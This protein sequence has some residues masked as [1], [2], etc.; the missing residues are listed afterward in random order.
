MFE[1]LRVCWQGGHL[2][3]LSAFTAFKALGASFDWMLVG[4]DDTLFFR[5]GAETAVREADKKLPYM[6]S[7]EKTVMK[8]C[9]HKRIDKRLD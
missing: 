7:G 3:D 1:R 4:E 2:E 6:I 8:E 5:E 9:Y